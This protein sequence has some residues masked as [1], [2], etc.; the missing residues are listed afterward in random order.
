MAYD[1]VAIKPNKSGSGSMSWRSS[2]DSFEGINFSLKQLIVN[3]YGI[4]DGLIS[5]MPAWAEGAHFD[6][7]AK[8]VDPD[9]EALTKLTPEQRQAMVA[10]ILTERFGLKVHKET[11]QLPVYE[12]T[13][14]KDGPKFKDSVAVEVDPKD[15]PAQR[16]G[17]GPGSMMTS[18]GQL[19]SVAIP[20]SSL[21]SMLASELSRTVI[22]KTGLAGK[23][24]LNLKWTPDR[25]AAAG[26]DDGQQPADVAPSLFTALQEQLGLKLVSSRG[27][28][29]TLVVDHVEQPSEN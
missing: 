18:D 29:E 26:T 8:I 19:K 4:R 9:A 10:S 7:H 24:D 15:D 25:V 6:I 5:G 1:A 22:D 14:L 13:V 20:L 27:P 11:K 3:A 12:L 28:V 16:K 2:D 23:Y 17:M 21:V